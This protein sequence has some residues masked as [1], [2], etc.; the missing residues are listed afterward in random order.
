MRARVRVANAAYAV[1]LLAAVMLAA[2][3]HSSTA[4]AIDAKAGIPCQADCECPE[5]CCVGATPTHAGVCGVCG[6]EPG[7]LCGLSDGTGD[8]ACVGGTCDSRHCCVLPDGAFAAPGGPV[9]L[10][11]RDAARR[12][13]APPPIDAAPAID[14][15]P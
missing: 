2:A 15:G 7:G 10:P 6:R 8:C 14:A 12:T 13:D 9:C 1:L 11:P 5:Y 3:C 4:A